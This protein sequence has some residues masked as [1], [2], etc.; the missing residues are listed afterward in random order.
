MMSDQA[1]TTVRDADALDAEVAQLRNQAR[2]LHAARAEQTGASDSK[3]G[4]LRD[5]AARDAEAARHAGARA[6]EQ[7]KQQHDASEDFQ[8]NVRALETTAAEAD[9]SGDHARAAELREEAQAQRALSVSADERAARADKAAADQTA[10][11]DQLEQDVRD[12]DKRI[13]GEGDEGTPAI[14]RVADQLDERANLL[15]QAAD[16]QRA[17]ARYEAEGNTEA[18]ARAMQSSATSLS[19]ADAIQ[20]SY[21]AVDPTLLN[22]AGIT[23]GRSA[24]DDGDDSDGPEPRSETIDPDRTFGPVDDDSDSGTIDSTD[25]LNPFGDG[26]DSGTETDGAAD[27]SAGEDAAGTESVTAAV[28]DT[29]GFGSENG[30]SAGAGFDAD[31][32]TAAF[33]FDEPVGSDDDFQDFAGGG[34]SMD[35]APADDLSMEFES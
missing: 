22:S 12:Y 20:P 6:T 8:V 11:A 27:A 17:A 23:I 3:W 19:Q 28:D 2:V 32:S 35:D 4:G 34:D 15:S 10:R 18:A 33:A 26:T 31:A 29:P 1:T 25:L 14:E 5:D 30:F 9:A 21:S 13:T 24:A 7:A 16:S